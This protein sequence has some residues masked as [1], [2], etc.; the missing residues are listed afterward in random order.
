LLIQPVLAKRLPDAQIISAVLFL[1]NPHS[2][3]AK[4]NL[5]TQA[6]T[7]ITG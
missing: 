6:I 1:S 4:T 3:L 5:A 7:Y 2:G